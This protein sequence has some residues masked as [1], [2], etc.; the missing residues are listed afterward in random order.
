MK[1]YIK[2]MPHKRGIKVFTRA[3]V[4]RIVYDFELY[5]GKGTMVNERGLGAGGE[6]VV[7]LLRDIPNG[8]TY[9]CFLDHWF[10]SPELLAEL[11]Q[12]GILAVRSILRNRL[13]GCVFKTDK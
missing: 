7:R 8:L 9:K 6:V 13:R 11:K 2:N 12:M 5:T 1:Q 10:P 3:G 4:C